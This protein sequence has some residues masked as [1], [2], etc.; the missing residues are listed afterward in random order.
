MTTSTYR[1]VN[2]ADLT[3]DPR[4]QRGEGVDRLRVKKMVT[5]FD[6]N[7][8]GTITVSERADGSMIVLDGMHR[9]DLC[10]QVD[11]KRPLHAHVVKGA[12][13]EEEAH[14]F[15]ALNA[16]KTPSS[17]SKFLVRVVMGEKA[18]VQMNEIV[19]S[20][21]W[22]IGYNSDPGFLAAV[23]ALERVY[24]NGGGTV[25]EGEH[26]DLVDR[27]L[28]ILTAAW[29][30]DGKAVQGHLML[31]VAQLLGRFGGSVDTKKLVSEM[32]STRPGVLIGKAKVLRDVQGGT[33]PAAL[34]KILAGMHNSKR[35]T[36]LLP[37]WV[38]I[39]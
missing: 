19:V 8:L 26:P 38:W 23:D 10:R 34:A 22:T 33:V 12:T 18:A 7:A 24:R 6:P 25:P 37:A 28:E 29:G 4:V 14:L 27:T 16:T 39:R 21:G 30:H 3:I 31:A 35:R 2:L 13:I 36:N 1:K 9:V 17:L 15:L 5:D 20:H 32:Q 11:H